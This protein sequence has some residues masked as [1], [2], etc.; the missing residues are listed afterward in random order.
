MGSTG[1]SGSGGTAGTAPVPT[2]TNGVKFNPPAVYDGSYKN[3]RQFERELEIFLNGYGVTDSEKKILIALSFMRGQ[4]A[5]DFVQDFVNRC[6]ATDPPTWGTWRDFK[7]TVKARFQNKNFAQE[8]RERLEHFKQGKMKVDDYFT[9]LDMMF[10]DAAVIDD[11]EKIRILEKGVDAKILETI[12]T[13]DSPLPDT[14]DAYKTKAIKLG[15]MR[16]RH[17]QISRIQTSSSSSSSS[18]THRPTP[19]IHTH[20]YPQPDKKTGSGITYGGK[21]QPM[22]VSKTQ[23]PMVCFNCGK[24]GHMRRDCP[25]EKAKMNIRVLMASLEDEEL[26]ELKAELNVEELDFVDG[27]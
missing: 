17:Q 23:R 26:Q 25:E 8:T 1:P 18:T 24:E 11:A 3:Y 12:Y 19:A 15:R 7:A 27:R 13:S 22:D 14:Y 9:Q 5:D 4:Y 10:T 20:I 21:G 6:T 2:S 16:E